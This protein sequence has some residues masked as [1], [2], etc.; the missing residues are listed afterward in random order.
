MLEL[1]TLSCLHI[2]TVSEVEV[3]TH[4]QLL[5]EPRDAVAA[6]ATRKFFVRLQFSDV[7]TRSAALTGAVEM[8]SFVVGLI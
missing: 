2:R 1:L 8:G 3:V 5:A 6:P 4:L 7:L